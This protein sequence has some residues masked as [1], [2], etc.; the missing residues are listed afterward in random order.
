MTIAHIFGIPV[1]ENV[2]QFAPF[3][4]VTATAVAMAGRSTLHR[5]VTRIR[6]H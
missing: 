2:V 6:R 5:F 4:A 1:E 3:G